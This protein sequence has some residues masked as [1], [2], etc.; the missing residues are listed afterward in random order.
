MKLSSSQVMALA[1]LS[2][3][4]AASAQAQQS[5]SV[6][7]YGRANVTAEN[8]K[9]GSK[10]ES[11]MVDNQSRVGVRA[12]R[13]LGGGLSVG[14]TLEAGVNFNNG[15]TNASGFF[16]RE[17]TMGLSSASMGQLRVG[18]MPA[19]AA[20]FA[21][22][23]Y[24]SNHNHDTGSSADALYDFLATGSLKNAVSYTTPKIG[25]LQMQAQYGLKKGTG[26]DGTN[27][28]VVHPMALAATYEMGALSW[29]LGHERGAAAGN[30]T[31]SVN[32]TTLRASYNLGAVG[33]GAYVERSG[34]RDNANAK[35]ANNRGD[36]SRTALRLSAM[37]TEG[38]NEFHANVGS[39][40]KRGGV[41]NTGATQ[42]T[43]GYNHNLDKQTKVY[44]LLTRVNNQAA[45]S[46]NPG[47]VFAG[48]TAGQDISAIG[49][50]LRYNF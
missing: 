23:D 17:A 13:G 28:S 37:Y 33:L 36:W 41:A 42:F 3:L 32:Q 47:R 16:A 5:N 10:S 43:M 15:V 40:G 50:G 22:A 14:A 24:I 48:P 7:V 6:A 25:D 35:A 11:V 39:A 9:V 2:L 8:Q 12:E 20:Y 45:A 21:T 19:S 26:V 30:S 49:V 18:R 31:N 29:G 46:Y 38:K 44:A 34:G 27:T 1:G 4:A